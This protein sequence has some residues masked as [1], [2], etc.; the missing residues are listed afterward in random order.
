MR[1]ARPP[2][3]AIEGA[4]QLALRV[5]LLQQLRLITCACSSCCATGSR[6]L[7]R[8]TTPNN[9]AGSRVLTR[10]GSTVLRVLILLA[11]AAPATRAERRRRRSGPSPPSPPPPVFSSSVVW[12]LPAP[13]GSDILGGYPQLDQEFAVQVFAGN[14]GPESSGASGSYNHNVSP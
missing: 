4:R 7:Q 5:L 12:D 6:W 9:M 3:L 1:G 13:N 14:Q 11:A 2:G 8:Q 10:A